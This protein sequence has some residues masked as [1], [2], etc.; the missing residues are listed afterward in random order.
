MKPMGI[1]EGIEVK[2]YLYGLKGALA[3]ADVA[4]PYPVAAAALG[5]EQTTVRAYVRSGQLDPFVLTSAESDER[6]PCVSARSLLQDVEQRDRQIN[7]LVEPVLAAL[8]KLKGDTIEYAKLMPQFGLSAQNPHHRLLI[9][10]VLGEVSY[11]TH[12][13]HG[14]LLTAVV[15]RKGEG[16]PSEPFF[17]LAEELNYLKP[18]GDLQSFWNRHIAKIR[19]LFARGVIH[20]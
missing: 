5:V 18:G 14:V 10:K 1:R 2:D 16:I 20:A 8:V 19:T 6:W 4:V 9:A 13:S 15:V 11:R 17:W 3:E 12:K 7:D